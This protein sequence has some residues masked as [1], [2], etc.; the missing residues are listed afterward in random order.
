[1]SRPAMASLLARL[2]EAPPGQPQAA[3][4]AHLRKEIIGN[5]PQK[6]AALALGL[7]PHLVR[8]LSVDR[9]SDLGRASLSLA[10]DGDASA[11]A[12]ANA[13]AADDVR[14]QATMVVGS[15]AHGGPSFVV[16]LLG[17]PIASLLLASFRRP[18]ASRRLILET[19]RTL[20][21]IADARAS[22][23]PLSDLAPA[24]LSDRLYSPESVASLPSLIVDAD[25]TGAK[26]PQQV[27]LVAR[28]I[29]KTCRDEKH[30][31][32]L[33]QAG[34]LDALAS[35]LAAS[36]VTADLAPPW[37]DEGRRDEEPGRPRPKPASADVFPILDA[38]ACI[39]RH[40]PQRGSH[41]VYAP[42]LLAVFSLVV[43][44][45]AGTNAPGPSVRRPPPTL[46]P[47]SED[48]WAYQSPSAVSMRAPRWRRSRARPWWP[49][50]PERWNLEPPST[51]TRWGLDGGGEDADKTESPVVPWLL[52]FAHAEHGL[53]R[54]MAVA[55]LTEIFRHRLVGTRSERLM[56]L[57]IVPLL[58][59]MLDESCTV[60]DDAGRYPPAHDPG[61]VRRVVQERGPAILG[62]LLTECALLQKVAVEAHAIKKLVQMLREAHGPV[63]E[64]NPT[65]WWSPT[66]APADAVEVEA[67][68]A[69]AGVDP[70]GVA[71]GPSP[72]PSPSPPPP[73]LGDEGIMSQLQHQF[74]V[75]ESTLHALAAL[76]PFRDEYRKSMLEHGVTPYLLRSLIADE[77][78]SVVMPHHHPPTTT[79][80]SA[81]EGIRTVPPTSPTIINPPAVLTAACALARALTRSVCILRTSMIDAGVSVPVFTLLH[82][83]DLRVKVAATMATCNLVLEFSPIREAIA[84]E[85]VLK[86]LC[87]HARSSHLPL[88]QNAI[89]A[90]K[91]LV[92]AAGNELK[93]A[94]IQELGHGWLLHRIFALR[95]MEL[96]GPRARASPLRRIRPRGN[97]F[98]GV[99]DGTSDGP[100]GDGRVADDD[101]SAGR[102]A[103]SVVSGAAGDGDGDG[104]A[105]ELESRPP[106]PPGSDGRLSSSTT[107]TATTATTAATAAAAATATAAAT[108]AATATASATTALPALCAAEADDGPDATQQSYEDE[109]RIQEQGLDLIR[110]LIY[111][112]GSDEMLDQLM[113]HV[114]PYDFCE[115]LAAKIL[116]TD[117]AP[118]ASSSSAAT[119]RRL[120]TNILVSVLFILVHVAAASPRHREMLLRHKALLP[121]LPPLLRHPDKR[122]RTA[123]VWIVI[124]ISWLDDKADEAGQLVR[125]AEMRVLGFYPEIE[126]LVALDPELDLRERART[127]LLQLRVGMPTAPAGYVVEG[128]LSA[129]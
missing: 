89:W 108:A 74:R 28:L 129:P 84:Q 30:R 88:Q 26:P 119:A 110:N 16:P 128:H 112:P 101:A 12:S 79:T 80:T 7:L 75:R 19:L 106:P 123:L 55:L 32:A 34:V 23:H 118:P 57:V 81:G 47:R 42:P 127:A 3:V 17:T 103:G 85:G 1:M 36:A 18:S 33:A 46:G 25:A 61:W 58:I 71:P 99:Y 107:A 68:V 97:G 35:Y 115:L 83:P 104:R 92:F 8:I 29:A 121:R 40:S 117:D 51:W 100:T 44:D 94:C 41:F 105:I 22:I 98:G 86:I 64:A 125:A 91:H 45:P 27:T 60:L 93:T 2:A 5:E 95:I 111:G 90:L 96:L 39:I 77:R 15:L 20:D 69:M 116:S 82:H 113:E 102:V 59:R 78:K 76:T 53:N 122:V 49:P 11:N 9:A 37:P 21:T 13:S 67:D 31:T 87:E 38:I 124:N 73:R 56:S 6:E 126:R 120:Q 109:L 63:C 70:G 54:L 48:V 14:W 43:R 50:L 52:Q 4:L 114:R 24:S 10:L 62:R 66:P 65:R 72:S